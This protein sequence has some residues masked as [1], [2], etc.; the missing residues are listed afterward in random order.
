MTAWSGSAPAIPG[1]GGGVV[2]GTEADGEPVVV[3]FFTASRGTRVCVIG[4]SALPKV[5]A[6]RAIDAG[7]RVQVVTSAPDN[8]FRLRGRAGLSAER[9]AVVPPGTPPPL[10]G[11]RVQLRM[12][13]DD[14]RGDGSG[15]PRVSNPW[16]AFVTTLSARDVTVAALRGLDAIVLYRSS[17]A[18][19]AAVGAA[20]RLPDSVVRSLHGIPRDVVAVVNAGQVRL[21]PLQPDA[22]E[23]ALFTELGLPIWRSNDCR[24]VPGLMRADSFETKPTDLQGE[25]A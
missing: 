14:T 9:L 21:V 25:V 13:L 7:A 16:Q 11:R 6:L 1:A 18:C 4:D 19:R 8:W 12:I 23:C 22:S 20:L 15:A 5:I 3:P 17:P 10:N 24:P 2:L